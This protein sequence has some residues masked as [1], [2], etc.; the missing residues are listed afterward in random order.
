MMIDLARPLL[1]WTNPQKAI[2]NN[3]NV[4]LAMFADLSILTAV[5]FGL[6]PLLKKG[7][8]GNIVV[9]ILF[10][11]LACLA[12]LSYMALLKFADKRY[13]DIEN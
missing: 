6:K 5:F 10:V 13:Q 7:V 4:L 8:E 12:A 3:F 11:A 9:A 2:K 1:D